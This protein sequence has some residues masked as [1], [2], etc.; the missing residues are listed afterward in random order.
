MACMNTDGN[1][2]KKSIGRVV[3]MDSKKYDK[4]AD[5]NANIIA[6]RPPNKSPNRPNNGPPANCTTANVVCKYPNTEELAPNFF[7]KY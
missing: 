5:T 2:D 1:L 7:V 4:A 6:S 3:D